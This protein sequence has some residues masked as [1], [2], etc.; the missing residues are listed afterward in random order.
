M[1]TPKLIGMGSRRQFLERSAA[2]GAV[3]VSTV[4]T[5]IRGKVFAADNKTI[6]VGTMPG[7]R[8]EG[9]LRASAAAYQAKAGTAI[10]LVV[11]PFTEHYQK[12]ATSLAT[13]SSNFDVFVFDAALLGQSYPK[14][15]QLDKL[16]DTD[17]DWKKYYLAGVPEAYRGSWSWDG[18]PYAVVHDAN[19]MMSWWRTDVFAANHLALPTTFEIMLEN[20]KKLTA[21]QPQSGF[22]TSA[23]RGAYLAVL[24]TGMMWAFGGRWWENDA[25]DRFGRV[26]K[27][28]PPGAVLL[29]SAENI[30][31]MTMLRDLIAAG[32]AGS[33]NAQEFENNAAFINGTVTQQLIW[34][35]LMVL[36]DEKLNPMYYNKLTSRDFP[37][38][39]NNKNPSNTGIK[40]GF[41]LAIP[42]ASKQVDR[43]FDFCR[44]VTSNE[45]ASNFIGG[46]GQPANTTLLRE[47]ST[48]PGFQV[49]ATIADGI[50]HGHHQA[51][52]PE[53]GQFY[54][55]IS[56]NTASVLTEGK[57]PAAACAQMK[58]D[59]ETLFKRAGYI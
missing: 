25:P 37:L 43:A 59:T 28:K 14:L 11:N 3:A 49:F 13:D 44:F 52:F 48:K 26:S 53:G 38:G 31:A 2:V 35:G 32:N 10:N 46:G 19:A 56:N 20:A 58:Q 50:I 6:T 41:G 29:N 36:Q 18:A 24:Y 5:G 1:D 33:L 45:N 8:W 27:E 7:P 4:V 34:S 12:I 57:D 23:S 22:M 30:A 9:A 55:I 54:D 40:G 39:G 42:K 15:A 47:W 17:P 51:Q 21:L 16:F